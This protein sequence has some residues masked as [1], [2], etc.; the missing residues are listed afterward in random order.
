MKYLFIVFTHSDRSKSGIV[1]ERGKIIVYMNDNSFGEGEDS[2]SIINLVNAV[3]NILNAQNEKDLFARLALKHGEVTGQ[4][5]KITIE[6]EGYFYDY[7][8]AFAMWHIFNH[9]KIEK[10]IEKLKIKDY[11]N[12]NIKDYDCRIA[13]KPFEDYGRTYIDNEKDLEKKNKLIKKNE[14]IKQPVKFQVEI[15]IR[16]GNV[17]YP[18]LM[19]ENFN[20]TLSS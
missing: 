17:L 9:P 2:V 18:S 5:E 4:N 1:T 20:F 6:V 10:N 15:N 7:I 12:R 13:M 16:N 8:C 14:Q 19:F 3:I 11:Y